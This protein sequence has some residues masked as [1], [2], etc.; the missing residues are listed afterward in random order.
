MLTAFAH[1]DAATARPEP[2]GTE[3]NTAVD[4][5]RTSFRIPNVIPTKL[6]PLGQSQVHQCH[7][8]DIST[9]GL[10][11]RV[12]AESGLSVGQRVE[13]VLGDDKAPKS[14]QGVTG[15]ACY[16]TVVR[17]QRIADAEKRVIGA[18]LRFDRPVFLEPSTRLHT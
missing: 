14:S 7:T 4:D 15:M 6:A 1:D 10:F 11:V 16:A 2:H 3:T 13:V 9:S 8:Q 5:R 17:T 18:G 12:P